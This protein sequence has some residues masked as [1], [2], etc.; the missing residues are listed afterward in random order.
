MKVAHKIGDILTALSVVAFMFII[1][2]IA[3]GWRMIPDAILIPAIIIALFTLL[4]GFI[5]RSVSKPKSESK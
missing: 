5:L 4:V 1:S 3:I 2:E